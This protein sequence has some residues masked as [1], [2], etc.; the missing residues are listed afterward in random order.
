MGSGH[1]L[2]PLAEPPPS[3]L[4]QAQKAA[5]DECSILRFRYTAKNSVHMLSIHLLSRRSV[6]FLMLGML[7]AGVF[8]T[9]VRAN[10]A[11]STIDPAQSSPENLLLSQVLPD[12]EEEDGFEEAGEGF[13]A[14]YIDRAGNVLGTFV[15]IPN[16]RIKVY[17]NGYI[18][19]DAQDYTVEMT[20][21]SNG[22]IREIGR[23]RF[24]YFGNGRIREIDDIDF[25]Y[26]SNGRLSAIES[27]DFD[28]F[29]SGRLKKIE[30]V[31]F[32]YDSNHL[33]ETISADR[34][35]SGIRIVVVD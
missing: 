22:K 6:V 9:P 25:R 34:T 1:S 17:A 28:Y 16:A 32:R 10:A 2:K 5:T 20:H 11:I 31:R 33:L 21:Y 30:E 4:I 18:V 29:S 24:R 3:T 27:V 19:V 14:I 7:N 12:F 23:T 15:N 13:H 26:F 8:S 35:R